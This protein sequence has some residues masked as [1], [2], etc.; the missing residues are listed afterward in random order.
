MCR[1]HGSH[2]LGRLFAFRVRHVCACCAVQCVH[3]SKSPRPWDRGGRAA[4]VQRADTLPITRVPAFSLNHSHQILRSIN[5]WLLLGTIRRLIH[6]KG[7]CSAARMTM[8][9]YLH[10]VWKG[11]SPLRCTHTY[12]S[13]FPND[14]LTNKTVI[15][16][17]A[18]FMRVKHFMQCPL[19]QLTYVRVSCGGLCTQF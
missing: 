16:P 15:K 8:W 18:Y 10:Y 11:P 17:S 4:L 19:P 1:S 9:R 7:T 12:Q 3:S 13:T 2:L 6:W 5:I 14:T